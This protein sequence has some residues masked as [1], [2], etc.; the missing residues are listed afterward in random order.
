MTQT[1]R[2]FEHLLASCFG[3]GL[4]KVLEMKHDFS[5]DCVLGVPAFAFVIVN[6][7]IRLSF[8]IRRQLQ[9]PKKLKF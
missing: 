6:V 7:M 4:H 5:S 3:M 9:K 2:K 8:L 1:L